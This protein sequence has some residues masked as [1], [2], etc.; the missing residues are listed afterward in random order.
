[1]SLTPKEAYSDIRAKEDDGTADSVGFQVLFSF[2]S[3]KNNNVSFNL[4]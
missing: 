4:F 1:M 3:I 2:E